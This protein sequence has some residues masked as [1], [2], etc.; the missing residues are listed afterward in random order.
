MKRKIYLLPL[1][2]LMVVAFVACDE[3]EEVDKYHD[4]KARNEAFVDSLQQVFDANPLGELQCF[5]DSRDQRV[6]IFYK[7][8]EEGDKSQQRPFLTSTAKAYYRGILIDEAIFGLS[9]EK[10][11]TRLWKEVGAFDSNF[12]GDDPDPSFDTATDFFINESGL[13]NGFREALQRMYPGARWEVY[14]PYQSG[15]GTSDYGSIPAYSTLIF[16]ITL[17]S[18]EY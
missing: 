16:D 4:W 10:Y 1:V 7:V 8:I 2:L 9:K 15:Y 13:R 17:V 3:T 12:S 14:I 11:Y 5:P 18:V 6:K